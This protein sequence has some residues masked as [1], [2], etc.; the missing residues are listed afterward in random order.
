MGFFGGDDEGEYDESTDL[1]HEQ[2]T[3]NEHEL[4][5]QRAQLSKTRLE[6]TH[7]MNGPDYSGSNR[8]APVLG[9]PEV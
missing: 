4:E 2:I 6:M 5:T 7:G 3:K 9:K 1:I 8:N